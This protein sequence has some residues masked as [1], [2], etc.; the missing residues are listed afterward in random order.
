MKNCLNWNVQGSQNS[1]MRVENRVTINKESNG[2]KPENSILDTSE[3]ED[4]TIQDN[5]NI[6]QIPER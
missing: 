2:L 3:R 1:L 4:L 6:S 5:I